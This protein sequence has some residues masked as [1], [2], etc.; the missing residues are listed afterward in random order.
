MESWRWVERF[1]DSGTLWKPVEGTLGHHLL[2]LRQPAQ[3]ER[4][5]LAVLEGLG[6]VEGPA[7][8]L[9]GAGAAVVDPGAVRQ[10]TRR[11]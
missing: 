5:L 4:P 11:R 6:T 10:Q 3:V 9:V 2:T 8:G 1:V 7:G